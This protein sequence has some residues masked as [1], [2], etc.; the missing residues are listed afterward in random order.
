[1]FTESGDELHP[2]KGFELLANAIRK[3]EGYGF[4]VP[5]LISQYRA[6]HLILS[7]RPR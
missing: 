2:R 5:T 3:L 4:E 1:M 7:Q 6:A